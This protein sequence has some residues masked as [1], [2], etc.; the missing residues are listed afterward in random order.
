LEKLA[1]KGKP[2]P[3]LVNRPELYPDL[4]RIWQGFMDLHKTRQIAFGPSAIPISEIIIWL[5]YQGITDI[6]ERQECYELI[7]A[8][9]AAWLDW[10][11]TKQKERDKQNANARSR[12]RRPQG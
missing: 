1:E 6:D 12:N 8:M 9:D 3:A 11:R 4:V 2:T 10:A 7:L 5:D